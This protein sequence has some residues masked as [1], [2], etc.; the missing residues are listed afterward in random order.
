MK[1][2]ANL[3][4]D[5]LN[6]VRW[7]PILNEAETKVTEN[8]G[9]ASLTVVIDRYSKR[10][11]V[12]NNTKNGM[13]VVEKKKK[14]ELKFPSSWTKTNVEIVSKVLTAL[15]S[16]WSVR[17]D[18]VTIKVEDGWVIVDAEMPWKYTNEVTK[19]AANYIRGVKGIIHTIQNKSKDNHCSEK[20]NVED[21]SARSWSVNDSNINVSVSGRA[22][23]LT[24][25][26]SSWYQK[27]EKGRIAWKISAIRNLKNE[28]VADCYY[29]LD[30]N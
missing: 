15:K 16:N 19:T 5:V 3:Q 30:D 4:T 27:E 24:G 10:I 11:E 8:G 6:I 14:M 20:N 26:V 2:N 25:T 18:H 1:N 12:E 29:D 17:K 23:T 7:I 13:A 28:L 22:V 9:I 21:A